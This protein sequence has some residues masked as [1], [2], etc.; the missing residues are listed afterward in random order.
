MTVVPVLS[1]VTPA[2]AEAEHL[3]RSLREIQR[4]AKALKVPYEIIV[5][6]DGSP[7]ETW[8]VIERLAD[9]TPEVQGVSLARNFGK[10]AAILAGLETARGDAVI[11][12][13]C[14]LQHPPALVPD[15]FA[16][17]RDGGYK[18]VNGYKTS[19]GRESVASAIGV[20]AFYR[21][22]ERLA[23]VRLAGASDYK[24]LDREV[25]NVYCGLPERNMF[26][27]GLI[28]WAGFK[29][30]DLPFEVEDRAAGRTKWSWPKRLYLA[31]RAIVSFSA[32]PLHFVTITG[33]VFMGLAAIMGIHTIYSKLSGGAIE[34][35]TTVILLL[36]VVGSV[37]MLSLG[38]IGQYLAHIYEELKQRPRYLVKDRVQTGRAGWTAPQRS[39]GSRPQDD[40][41]IANKRAAA[42]QQRRRS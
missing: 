37:L 8:Q 12:M 19:R 30:V 31:A 26:F 33:L 3:E 5:V 16:L 36:L 20:R 29:Q 38:V 25:V 13:D 17:W 34:G 40:T 24:L 14:D 22:F 9:K 35:F 41:A 18:V 7:D 1:I 11:V 32:A 10:E 23:N 39:K 21:V 4:Q 27:R 6:D 42:A 2:Y 15:L 28:S